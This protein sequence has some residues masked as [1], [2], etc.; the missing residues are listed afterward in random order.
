MGLDL[1]VYPRPRETPLAD[2]KTLNYL[3]YYLAGKWARRAGADEAVIL[4]PDGSV[5]ETNTANI[6]CISGRE[7]ILPVSAHVLPGIMAS[8]AADYLGENGYGITRK[9]IMPEDL[10]GFDC[11]IL[12]NSLMGAVPAIGLD[13]APMR[14]EPGLCSQINKV[15]L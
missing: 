14:S 8:Q 13:G 2:H 9:R 5:S 1:A 15:V 4:N 12:T 11:V 3:Y 7:A 10:P 6:I